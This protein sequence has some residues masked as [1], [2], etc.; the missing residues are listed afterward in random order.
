MVLTTL[1]D[2][3]LALLNPYIIRFEDR[4]GRDRRM[5]QLKGV[6]SIVNGCILYRI[7]EGVQGILFMF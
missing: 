3:I 6:I 5:T 1:V 7:I 4:G 2:C